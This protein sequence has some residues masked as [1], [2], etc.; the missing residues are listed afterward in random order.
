MVLMSV[1]LL[2]VVIIIINEYNGAFVIYMKLELDERAI[3]LKAK[4]WYG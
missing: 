1:S 3:M 4:Q 2:L